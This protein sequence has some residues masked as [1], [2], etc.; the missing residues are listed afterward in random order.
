MFYDSK[1]AIYQMNRIL[2]FC[3]PMLHSKI[4]RMHGA[5]WGHMEPFQISLFFLTQ[6]SCYVICIMHVDTH[7]IHIIGYYANT[8]DANIM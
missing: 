7:E 4:M 1:D 2:K 6:I 8:M 3:H 5:I